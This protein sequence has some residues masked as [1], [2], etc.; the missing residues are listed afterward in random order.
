MILNTLESGNRPKGG[1]GEYLDGVPSLGGEH[2][3]LNGRIFVNKDNI[4][5]VPTD[6]FNAS[7]QGVLN[8]LDI[9]ICK[10]GALTGKVALFK[11]S[12]LGFD[13]SMINEHVFLLRTNEKAIQHYLFNILL[14]KRGQELLKSNITGQGQGGLNRANLLDIK[15]PLPPLDIQQKI[16]SEIEVLEKKEE[17]ARGE[18]ENF[19]HKI[20]ELFETALSKANTILRLN[21]DTIFEVSIGKRVLK[22][23]F[24]PNGKIPVYSANVIEPFGNINKLLI[25]DFSKPSV[26]W[27]ID[28][29]WMVSY[30]PEGYPFYPTDHCGVLR[31]KN[32]LVN[33][34]YLTFVLEKE[35]KAFGFSRTKRASIDRIK[36]IKISV[37]TLSEQEKTVSEIEKIETQIEALEKEI[38]EIPKQKEAILKKWLN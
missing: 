30:V 17:K 5:Y 22:N 32:N 20:T 28:G 7:K 25:E 19:N 38:A 21:D 15:I 24:V 1:V 18:I 36:G 9:L 4:K 29:D 34:K 10:D 35:G 31:V 13:S 26:L 33:E 6:Y 37:P 14:S 16:V 23:E 11:I 8:D 12:D 3:G 27:G 2:I